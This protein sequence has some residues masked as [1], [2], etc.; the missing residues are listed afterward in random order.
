MTSLV[1][2]FRAQGNATDKLTAHDYPLYYEQIF[3]PIRE[4][5]ESVLE[6]GIW[7][8]GSLRCW[9]DYFP[10]AIVY[11]L[12]IE[13]RFVR[14]ANKGKRI[15]AQVLDVGER[16]TLRRWAEEVESRFDIVIDDGSHKVREIE[17]AFSVLWWLVEPGGYY[18]IEDA[19]QVDNHVAM[20][21]M[22]ANLARNALLGILDLEVR[23]N[24][25]VL[26]KR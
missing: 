7:N 17:I 25:L 12:D 13:E 2:L 16:E 3:A 11:G 22:I 6:I 10:N 19:N 8:G 24:M 9:R 5:V 20:E 4:S 23:E 1:D 26:R 21:R 15:V 14:E 18:I